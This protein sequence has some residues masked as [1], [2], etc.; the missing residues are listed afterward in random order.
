MPPL[1][2]PPWANI[3]G[4]K[5]PMCVQLSGQAPTPSSRG[6]ST[7]SEGLGVPPPVH[8]VDH[9]CHCQESKTS[10]FT[11]QPSWRH[12]VSSVEIRRQNGFIRHFLDRCLFSF[13]TAAT[14]RRPPPRVWTNS[15][16]SARVCR[17]PQDGWDFATL[18][19]PSYL[20][21]SRSL[22]EHGN[23]ARCTRV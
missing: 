16:A 10:K 9:S 4:K 8:S 20:S 5:F 6:G 2:P 7:R 13:K 12:E 3:T 21:R 18:D 14:R 17:V 15:T 22:S 23:W 19:V 11:G 1:L